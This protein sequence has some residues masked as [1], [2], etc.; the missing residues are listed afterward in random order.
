MKYFLVLTVILLTG[1]VQAEAYDFEVDG[2]YYEITSF[3]DLT[4]G[5]AQGENEYEGD[6][7]IPAQ[8]EYNNRLL[9][10]QEIRSRAFNLCSSLTSIEIPNSVTVIGE[11]AF[12]YCS[13]LTSIEIPNSVTKIS[14]RAF[15]DCVRLSSINIPNSVIEIGDGAFYGCQSL[16]SIEIPN[17]VTVI[18]KSAFNTCTSLTTVTLPNSVTKIGSEAFMRCTSLTSIEI[19][20]SVTGIGDNAFE[21]CSSLTS[22]EIPNSVISIGYE[23]FIGCS[24]LT[25][26]ELSTSLSCIQNGVF[27]GC[28][29]LT[30]ITIPGSVISIE[31]LAFNE[32]S[33]LKDVNLSNGL[34]SIYHM[35]F[36]YCVSLQSITIPGSVTKFGNKYFHLE[37]SSPFFGCNSLKEVNFLYGPDKLEILIEGDDDNHPGSG[38]GWF[39][40]FYH[41]EKMF[42]DRTFDC[43]SFYNWH[44]SCQSKMIPLPNIRELYIGEH[45]QS[46]DI[47]NIETC[48]NLEKIRCYSEVPP[49]CKKFSNKQYMNVMV[50]VPYAALEAYRYVPVW[51]D[52][53]NLQGF[54][55]TGIEDLETEEPE[56]SIIGRFD[57]NG[58]P[59]DDGNKGITIIRF[60]DG[61]AEKV[62]L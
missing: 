3:K 30:S 5:V 11:D 26:V 62:I 29:S 21:G 38:G 13:K 53:W 20:N 6:I 44:I 55:P 47:R 54:E 43:K 34:K 33:A 8:V 36:A 42:I 17:S 52:F 56:K 37:Y 2:I 32:C 48:E 58:N 57:L 23:V 7:V 39:D 15:V 35:A 45:I 28:K 25:S 50:E 40:F 49:S 4:C 16:T 1:S 60:S 19:P 59:V 51:G 61:S 31:P 27:S 22:I 24:S 14:K 18:G 12:S 9:K 46:L 10:V 41:L